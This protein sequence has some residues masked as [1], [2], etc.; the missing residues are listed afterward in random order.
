M[1]KYEKMSYGPMP[2][3]FCKKCARKG[4]GR[5]PYRKPFGKIRNDLCV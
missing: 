3:Y 5:N 4:G 2:E 1:Q